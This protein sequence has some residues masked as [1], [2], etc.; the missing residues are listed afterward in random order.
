MALLK[1]EPRYL[2][3]DERMPEEKSAAEK[4]KEIERLRSEAQQL[5]DGLLASSP[6][7]SSPIED[8]QA[9]ERDAAL[10]DLLQ[11]TGRLPEL[12]VKRPEEFKRL[13]AAAREKAESD[14]MK[15]NRDARYL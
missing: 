2:R 1:T 5:E 12:F 13:Q 9:K 7:G 4:L 10:F 11:R 8:A 15:K 3:G 6:N 14:L